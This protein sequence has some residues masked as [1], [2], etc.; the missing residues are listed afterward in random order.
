MCVRSLKHIHVQ[1]QCRYRPIARDM[2]Q[3]QPQPPHTG[4]GTAVA[5]AV[6]RERKARA[7]AE[8]V[9]FH[10]CCFSVHASAR[11]Q[12]GIEMTR[13]LIV[14]SRI[15]LQ[16]S[17][18]TSEHHRLQLHSTTRPCTEKTREATTSELLAICAW[19]EVIASLA[20][21]GYPGLK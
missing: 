15:I 16:P 14:F 13:A 6:S 3:N 4:V 2:Q 8:G 12:L 1:L 9:L 11:W 5:K 17:T 20:H 7:T 18:N 10:P 19:V 21:R